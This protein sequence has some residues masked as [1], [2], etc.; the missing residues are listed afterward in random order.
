MTLWLY[1]DKFSLIQGET[2]YSDGAELH[3]QIRDGQEGNVSKVL[4]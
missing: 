3:R 1:F 2:A 4:Y